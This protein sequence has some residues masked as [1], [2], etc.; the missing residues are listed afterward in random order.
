MPPWEALVTQSEA[1][2]LVAYIDSIYGSKPAEAKEPQG[3]L[4]KTGK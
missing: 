2:D 4:V 3:E 1:V